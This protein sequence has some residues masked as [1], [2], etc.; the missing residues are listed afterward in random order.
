M[1]ILEIFDETF[2]ECD[3]QLTSKNGIYGGCTA[4]VS[5]LVPGEEDSFAIYT[6]NVG[7]ARAVL[8][9]T[10]QGVKRLTKD[11]KGSDPQEQQ[12]VREA[13]GFI[14]LDRVSGTQSL[15]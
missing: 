3:S 10:T 8:C 1:T 7:D 15:F 2:R 13:G 5:Y 11:H 9:S 12:R 14:A 4:V 6:A